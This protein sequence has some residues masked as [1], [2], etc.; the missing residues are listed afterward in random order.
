MTKP[1]KG[2]LEDCPKCGSDDWKAAS[3]VHNAGITIVDTTT[4]STGAGIG[5]GTGGIG[6]GVG[7]S[8]GSTAGTLQNKVSA[9]I[10]PPVKPKNNAGTIYWCVAL[11]VLM[12]AGKNEVLAGFWLL[13]VIMFWSTFSANAK[14]QHETDVKAYDEALARWERSRVCQRCGCL[15]D[16]ESHEPAKPDRAKTDPAIESMTVKRAEKKAIDAEVAKRLSERG[17]TQQDLISSPAT[18]VI[19]TSTIDAEVEKALV[20]AANERITPGEGAYVSFLLVLALL[21]FYATWWIGLLF[22]VWTLIYVNKVTTRH[23]EQILAEGKAR[24]SSEQKVGE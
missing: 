5:V 17:I 20:K 9:S 1:K 24:M 18:V 21:G 3:F 12:M 22:V 7:V 10:T 4:R 19:P 16:P 11:F 23:K 14:R 2:T 13:G 8:S 6:V 15:Y